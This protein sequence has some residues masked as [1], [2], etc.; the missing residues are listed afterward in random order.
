M[1][2]LLLSDIIASSPGSSPINVVS[3]IHDPGN[4]ELVA[5]TAAQEIIVSPEIISMQLS[6]ISQQPVLE[7]I[8]QELLSAGGIEICIKPAS[9]YVELHEPCGFVDVQLAAQG[10]MEVAIGVR[11]RD[12]SAAFPAAV[13]LNPRRDIRWKFGPNDSVVVLA[14]EIYD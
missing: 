9:R 4:R 1:L 3:E 13:Q 11:V 10:R 14:Q 7:S 8:Y 2:L 6:Q 5:R 12:S